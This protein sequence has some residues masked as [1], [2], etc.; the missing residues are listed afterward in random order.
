MSDRGPCETSGKD[1]GEAATETVGFL[2]CKLLED[3]R[4]RSDGSER[5]AITPDVLL[6]AKVAKDAKALRFVLL[7][8]VV[9]DSGGVSLV[10]STRALELGVEVENL[11]TST[12][13]L[14]SM[15][16]VGTKSEALRVLLLS[17]DV[18]RRWRCC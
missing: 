18:S 2:L 11:S 16:S 6:L 15:G 3:C 14:E 5:L 7:G 12:R 8:V 9:V 13:G 17:I 4:D 1:G 10:R